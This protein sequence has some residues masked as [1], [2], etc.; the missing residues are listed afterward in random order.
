MLVAFR[1][2][3]GRRNGAAFTGWLYAWRDTLIAM[4]IMARLPNGWL[5]EE[6][7]L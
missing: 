3:G 2:H 1:I 6:A 5:T 4:R 7:W